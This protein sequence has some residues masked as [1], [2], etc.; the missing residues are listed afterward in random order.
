MHPK[1]ASEPMVGE[2]ETLERGATWP[3]GH[4][5][6]G[7]SLPDIQLFL[8]APALRKPRATHSAHS[9]GGRMGVQELE[10]GGFQ[11]Q[12]CHIPAAGTW[13][14][15]ALSESCGLYLENGHKV[16]ASQGLVMIT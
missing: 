15:P 8:R 14:L 1:W 5:G 6:G 11:P 4:P 2:E 12:F 16:S 9:A 7:S 10:E 13:Q 3:E